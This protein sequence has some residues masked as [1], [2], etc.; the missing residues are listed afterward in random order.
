MDALPP[1]P[2]ARR[3]GRP[4]EWVPFDDKEESSS[5]VCQGHN[6]TVNAAHND[7]VRR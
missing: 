7:R 6:T 2:G 5:G 4:S 3:L 1:A